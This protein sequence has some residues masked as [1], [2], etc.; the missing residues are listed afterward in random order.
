[1]LNPAVCPSPLLHYSLNFTLDVFFRIASVVNI[2][3][4]VSSVDIVTIISSV[5]IVGIVIIVSS[6]KYCQYCIQFHEKLLKIVLLILEK[7]IKN[8]SCGYKFSYKP[9]LIVE[10]Y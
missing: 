3:N 2:V 5:S 10:K 7:T 8:I 4:I 9:A 6:V 1:M